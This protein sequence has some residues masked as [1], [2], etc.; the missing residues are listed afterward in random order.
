MGT[1]LGPREMVSCGREERSR[2]EVRTN[3]GASEG[4]GEPLLSRRG[5]SAVFSDLFRFSITMSEK[6]E[7][8]AGYII[9]MFSSLGLFYSVRCPDLQQCPRQPFC[10]LSHRD[11]T[12]DEPA[13]D[14][15]VSS[16]PKQPT[17]P[18]SILP[19]K[20]P[21][22]STPPVQPSSEPPRKLQRL[23]QSSSKPTQSHENGPP[24][25]RI[26]A[27]QSQVA[28]PVRQAMLKTLYDHFVI[29][30]ERILPSN[31]SLASEHAL[32]QE[33]EIYTK[34]GKI[35]YRHAVI[36]SVAALK[37]RPVPDSAA[38]PSVG[39]EGEIAAR[40]ELQKSL[41]SLR[42]T[43]SIL[44]PYIL[45][46]TDLERWGYIVNIPDGPGGN[47]PSKE[48]QLTK[49]ERCGEPFLVRR[50]PKPNECLHHWGRPYGKQIDGKR[51]RIYSCCSKAVT[52]EGCVHGSHVFYESDAEVL[53]S[54]HSFSKLSSGGDDN[55]SILDVAAL[56]CEMVYTTGGMRVAR[57]SVVDGAG[58]QVFDE[59]VRMDEGV[60]ILDFNTRFS[61][62]TQDEYRSKALLTLSSIRRSLD[63]FING[64]TVLIGHALE[65]DLKTLRIVHHR[66]VD[67]AVMFP[68]HVG[69]PYRRALRDLV[70]DH[71]GKSIQVGGGTVGHS[72]LED[73]IATLD[74]VR[75][76]IRQQQSANETAFKPGT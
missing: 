69:P 19:A 5:L 15:P 71:L 9:I 66:C 75:W 74:L 37:R 41:K 76:R 12:P 29:L 1:K 11:D 28:L 55:E 53:H 64:E 58:T 30:Y 20:R 6:G 54:R 62:I 36:Q 67:T 44:E 21:I 26:N 3:S 61:G 23:S 35:T 52:E 48:G 63:A 2:R 57:V 7:G 34:S 32:K 60:E 47:E 18:S 13:L 50:D 17:G 8:R 39:T 31:P 51:N 43:R 46:I 73:A 59:L 24:V 27:A 56:D 10:V 45:P 70:R 14:I 38:H 49:C 4:A 16:P 42:L 33:G 25:L 40:A 72:S 68:H 65:N 22:S